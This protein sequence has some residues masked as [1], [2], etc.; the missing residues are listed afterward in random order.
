MKGD[1][2]YYHF[3]VDGVDDRGWGCGYRSLQTLASWCRQT[4][5]SPPVPSHSVIQSTIVRAGLEPADFIGSKKW[6]G[7][8]EVATVLER[9]YG[10][11][12]TI[13]NVSSGSQVPAC[14]IALGR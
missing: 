4:D 2:T 6:I 10:V 8:M 12:C 3:V 11:P 7:S 13:L 14:L 9:L 5:E 1:Y